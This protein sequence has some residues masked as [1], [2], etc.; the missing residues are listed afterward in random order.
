MAARQAV[1]SRVPF[2]EDHLP[3]RHMALL[4]PQGRL[5]N[6][7]LQVKCL[8]GSPIQTIPQHPRRNNCNPQMARPTVASRL[9]L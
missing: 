6:L 8:R 2:G 5:S 1:K 9:I 3:A 7:H 4:R